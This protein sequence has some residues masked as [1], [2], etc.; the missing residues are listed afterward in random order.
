MTENLR[1][2]FEKVRVKGRLELPETPSIRDSLPIVYTGEAGSDESSVDYYNSGGRG[3][4]FSRGST[5][6]RVK[7]VDPFGYLTERVVSSGKNR[8][9]DVVS[10]QKLIEDQIHSGVQRENMLFGRDKPFGVFFVEQA[11]NERNTCQKLSGVYSAFGIEDPCQFL[12]YQETGVEKSGRKTYQT[13]FRLPEV[14]SDIRLREINEL[15]IERLDECTPE[16]IAARSKNINRLYGRFIYWAGVSSALMMTGGL[17]PDENSFLCQNWILNRYKD[18]YGML[19]VDHTSTRQVGPEEAQSMVLDEEEGLPR[20]IN[21]FSVF[22]SKVQIA[23][24]P[25][26]FLAKE[27]RGKKFREILTLREGINGDERY[28][29][30]AHRNAFGMGFVSSLERKEL[31]PIPEEM[32]LEAL[33]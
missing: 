22:P 13:A 11:E 33:A 31:E 8:I 12:H 18:G 1:S 25:K 3:V 2:L 29:I 24:N 6:Y 30:D 16:Q 9:S 15:I 28:I 5:H 26:Q 17:L 19:R 14:E 32:L 27:H 7:G 23:S 20:I 4:V 10:A 21:N